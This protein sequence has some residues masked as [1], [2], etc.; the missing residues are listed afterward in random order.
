[1]TY[2]FCIGWGIVAA[3]PMILFGDVIAGWIDATPEVVAT[4]AF[5][6]AIVPWS[7]GLWGILMMTSASF[8]A[9]GKPIPSTALSFTRMFVLYIPLALTLNHLL[10]YEGIFIATAVSNSVMGILGYVWFRR[11]F[12]LHAR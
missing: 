6:L 5:Y 7:Y 2:R 10:D 4:A 8:N 9:L 11:V 12:P 3:L 1:V